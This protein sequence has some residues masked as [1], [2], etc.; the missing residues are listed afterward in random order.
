MYLLGMPLKAD[1][2]TKRR[3]GE[4]ATLDRQGQI[5]AEFVII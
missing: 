5:D 3:R 4:G 2:V 1:W